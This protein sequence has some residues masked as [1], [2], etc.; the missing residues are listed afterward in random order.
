METNEF[1]QKV[2]E[3]GVSLRRKVTEKK[4]SWNDDTFVH[5]YPK[6]KAKKPITLEDYLYNEWC[7]GGISGGSCWDDGSDDHHYATSGEPETDFTDLDAIL[8][9]LCPN[10]S[11]LQYKKLTSAIIKTDSRTEHE[12][13]GNSTNYATKMVKLGDL[14]EKLKEMS[15]I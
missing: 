13:Y 9:G 12:Y 4:H 5:L 11:F 2:N 10:L 7:T 14:Y 1:L 6:D 3:L 8:E 15:L